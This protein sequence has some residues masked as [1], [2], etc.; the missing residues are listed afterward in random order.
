MTIGGTSSYY[1]TNGL[2][3]TIGGNFTN[4]NTTAASNGLN[5]GGFRPQ[6]ITQSTAFVGSIDQTISGTVS[7]RTNFANLEIATSPGH[8]SSLTSNACNITIN[9]NLTLTS[10]ILNDGGNNINLLNN[11]DNNAVHVSSNP[12]S[13]GMIFNGTVNQGITG[14]GNGVFGNIE[15]NNGGKNVKMTDNTTINGQLKF[16][17][18]YLYIDDYAL[19]LGQSAA[20]AGTVNA[21]NLILL[22]GVLSDRGVTKIFPT[23]ASTF[24]FPIGGNGKYTPCTFNFLS[25]TNPSG[26]TIKVVPVDELHPSIDPASYIN[27][28]N[29]YW[30]VTAAG[31]SSAF[32]VTHSYTYISL[33]VEGTPANIERCD[34]AT[35]Q[36]STV[37]GTISSPTFSFTSTSLID[38][39]YTIGDPFNSLPVMTSI[40][41]GNWNDP[42]VWSTNTVPN[43]NPV[44]IRSTDSIALNANSADASSV[45]VN[46]VLDA[47]NTTFHNIGQ[48]SGT[49]KIKLLS[50]GSGMFVFPGGSFDAFFTNPASTLEF[51]GNINGTMPLNPGN[52]NK[53]YQNVIISGTGIKY[54]SSIDIKINGTLTISSGSKL[55]NTLYNKDLTILGNWIDN[56]TSGGFNDGT[57]KVQFNGTMAQNIIMANSSTKETFYNLEI[58]NTAGVT[59]NTGNVDIDNKLFLTSGNINTSSTNNLTLNNTNTNAVVGGSVSSFVNGPLRKKITNGSNF[60]FPVGDAVSSGRIRLGYVSVSSTSTTGTQIWTTQF[61]DKNPTSDGYNIANVTPPLQSVV[62]NEYWNIVGPTGGSANVVLSW[63]QYT[64]MSSSAPARALTAVAEWN[65]PVSSSWNSVGQTVTDNGQNSGTVAT[66]TLVSLE[67]HIFTIGT[68]S[69]PI[70]ITSIQSGNWNNSATWDFKV[71]GLNDTV[72]IKNGNTVTL[73]VSTTIVKLIVDNGGTFDNGTGS[74]TLSL[75]GNFIFNGGWIGSGTGKISMTTDNDTI[76]GNGSLTG[77]S[78]LEIAGNKVIDVSASPTLANVSLVS[79]KTLT[80]NG[81]VTINDLTGAN[82]T[83]TFVNLPG[84]TLIINGALLANGTLDASTCANTI[85]Y[86]GNIVQIIKPATYCNIIMRGGGA[87][88]FSDGATL[89]AHGDVTQEITVPVTNVTVGTAVGTATWQIDG[90]LTTGNG[91]VNNGDISI[92]N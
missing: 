43:G 33:D 44:V 69:M 85:I 91:F 42:S 32:N 64:G 67:N 87:K 72:H 76:F 74:N 88:T 10:G 63:D 53:P 60:Q 61:Y 19:I 62:N 86:N 16:T 37:P 68:R 4:N 29:Y 31:F 70:M 2:N 8:T 38:G 1:N 27:Y 47:E 58:N 65:T 50:T 5:V 83:S 6:V 21:S 82:A 41:S 26:G 56:N 84:S 80:N 71:P 54:I 36:W 20:I 24:T 9:G 30:N 22:N 49:G 12:A 57:G 11:V 73:N 92:G 89:T 34:N 3:I 77:T 46:G 35:S 39:S 23:G 17:N 13:G 66:S 81:T 48:V 52:N 15:I 79:G 55:D 59:I 18:G 7:N 40:K 14:S 45:I 78:T 25:N 75:A 90:T 28:L 51:Y